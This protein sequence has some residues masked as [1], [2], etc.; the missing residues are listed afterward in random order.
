VR[1]LADDHDGVLIRMRQHAHKRGT[2]MV[3]A[4]RDWQKLAIRR[5]LPMPGSPTSVTIWPSP[6][7]AVFK[8]RPKQTTTIRPSNERHEPSWQ[9]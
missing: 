5:G 8:A 1:V 6:L 3:V 9:H 2:G 7:P 4:F